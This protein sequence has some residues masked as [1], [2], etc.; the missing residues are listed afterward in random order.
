M[1]ISSVAVASALV[2]VAAACG[3]SSSSPG[4]QA[5]ADGGHGG[6]DGGGSSSSGASSSSSGG[7][8]SSSGSGSSGSSSGGSGSSGG[9]DAG[10][11]CTLTANETATGN[12]HGGCAL[13]TRDTSGCQASR[14]AAGLSGFWLKFSCRVTLGV[15][16]SSVSV[17]SDGRPDHESNYFASTDPCY[18][19]YTP[20]F[21]DPNQIAVHTLSFTV[22]QSPAQATASSMNLGAVGMAV[23]G[24]AIFD[25]QAAPGDDIFTEAYSFDQCQGHPAP[26][27]Q[28]HYHTEPWA[29]SYDD[30]AFIGV[31]RDGFPV[32]GRLDADGSTPTLDASGGHVGTTPDSPSTAV[33]HYHVNLQTDTSGAHAGDEGWFLTTGKY[34]GTPGTCSGC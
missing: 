8:S 30:D 29:I 33:Y 15:S 9:S 25:N 23:D 32:Y 11:G 16:G 5:G 24:S 12:V 1:R 3:G 21:P 10:G 31:M 19:P 14:T 22:P 4:A 28:Y 26:G 13:V 18:T 17:S 27:G 34:A 6:A 20:S 7:S 2:L